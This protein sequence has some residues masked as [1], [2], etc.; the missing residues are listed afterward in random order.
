MKRVNNILKIF[1]LMIAVL[2][3]TANISKAVDYGATMNL[4]G[5]KTTANVGDTVTYTLALKSATNVEGVATVHAKINYDKAVLQYVS[6]EA[7]NSWSAPV[8]NEANQEF[9][10]ERSDVMKPEGNIIKVTFKVIS[11][12][13]NKTTTVSITNFDVADTD[14]QITVGDVSANLKIEE[15]SN[16]TSNDK[17]NQ[18]DNKNTDKPNNN[19]VDE[20]NKGNNSENNNT[21]NNTNTPSKDN[22]TQ[23]GKMPQTGIYTVIPVVIVTALIV[24][25]VILF[26]KYKDI[27]D[28]K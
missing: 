20:P 27:K 25:A 26:I 8:Y 1:F 15:K 2:L 6:C 10:T 21:N 4:T 11:I 9:V 12:P 5:S 28:I 22:T 3:I 7:T 14:N 17:P 19:V 16:N 13:A 18:D 24:V 23:D